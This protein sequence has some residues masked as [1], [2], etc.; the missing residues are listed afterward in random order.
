MDPLTFVEADAVA[1]N[2]ESRIAAIKRERINDARLTIVVIK[3]MRLS[4]EFVVM[5]RAGRI[6]DRPPHKESLITNLTE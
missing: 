5:D 3:E 2:N 4:S 6:M 1:T